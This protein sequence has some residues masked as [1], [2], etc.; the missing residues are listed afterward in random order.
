VT[1][2]WLSSLGF[3][4]SNDRYITGILKSLGFTDNSGIP[5][6]KWQAYRNKAQARV[7]MAQAIREA[8]PGLFETYPDAHRKDDEA[9]RNFFSTHTSVGAAAIAYMV[10]TFKT[11][12]ELADFDTTAPTLPDAVNELDSRPA[13]AGEKPKEAVK[14]PPASA[15]PIPITMNIQ[16]VIP[17]DATAEQYDKIFSS[18]KKHL[19]K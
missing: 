19:L 2:K 16:I 17:S 11:L 8:Y 5:T 12:A 10:R 3:K 7:V 6:S 18:I 1:F 9:L 4:T 14:S 15:I 13:A